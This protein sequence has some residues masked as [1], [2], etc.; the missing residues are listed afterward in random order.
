MKSWVSGIIAPLF[1]TSALDGGGWPASSPYS[2]TPG[3]SAPTVEGW[4]G[5]GAGLH[6]VE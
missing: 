3:E 2:F 4:V 1:L 5:L 6:A